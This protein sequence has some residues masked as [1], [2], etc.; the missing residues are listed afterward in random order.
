[1]RWFY[2]RLFGLCATVGLLVFCQRVGHCA[3]GDH[4]RTRS[5]RRAGARILTLQHKDFHA[6]PPCSIEEFETVVGTVRDQDGRIRLGR[7]PTFRLPS[8]GGILEKEETRI[9]FHGTNFMEKVWQMVHHGGPSARKAIAAAQFVM[10]RKI[11]IQLLRWVVLDRE[12]TERTWYDTMK[13]I[14]CMPTLLDWISAERFGSESCLAASAVRARTEDWNNWADYSQ[15]FERLAAPGKIG[16]THEIVKFVL[17]DL[18]VAI[19]T[20]VDSRSDAGEAVELKTVSPR[21]LKAF[22]TSRAL[23]TYF[24]LLFSNCQRLCLG[25]IDKGRLTEVTEMSL[26]QLHNLLTEAGDDLDIILGRLAAAMKV[27]YNTCTAKRSQEQMAGPYELRYRDDVLSLWELEA[28]QVG[29]E[30][31]DALETAKEYF[32]TPLKVS[33]LS[34]E[35]R[36]FLKQAMQACRD[37][38]DRFLA[39]IPEDVVNKARKRVE[40]EN[41]L[42]L[43]EYVGEEGGILNPVVLPLRGCI[44]AGMHI[45]KPRV[46]SS[47]LRKSMAAQAV[48]CSKV[49]GG[50][51]EGPDVALELAWKSR[52]MDFCMPYLIQVLREYTD[53]VNA[54][55]KKTCSRRDFG[56]GLCKGVRT[57]TITTTIKDRRQKKEEE[58]EKQKSAVRPVFE[59]PNDYVPDY[60]MPHMAPG[61]LIQQGYVGADVSAG[62]DAWRAQTHWEAK[63]HC[64][65]HHEAKT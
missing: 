27:I 7:P 59:A 9:S 57:A 56:I 20:E 49:E 60:M 16:D 42:N 40:D 21:N 65:T 37:K 28:S 17:G 8:H 36:K 39:Y 11:L 12:F 38:L 25:V 3:D 63:T 33:G 34:E 53:R 19:Y 18:D 29:N 50:Q 43:A 32:G 13:H 52:N 48:H 58:E 2:L 24:E 54:L 62:E 46:G 23:N 30:A 44:A 10:P 26:P 5:C 22:R 1:M 51:E 15:A 55:D 4:R 6:A 47:I 64:E 41:A 35:Q 14:V 45:L 61:A 31:V